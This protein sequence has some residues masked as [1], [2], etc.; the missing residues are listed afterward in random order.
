MFLRSN[1][2][3]TEV[4]HRYSSPQDEFPGSEKKGDF[5][6]SSTAGCS[7]K[8]WSWTSRGS[9]TKVQNGLAK[10]EQTHQ[11]GG[12]WGMENGKKEHIS[13]Q[14]CLYTLVVWT[15]NTSVIIIIIII[16]LFVQNLFLVVIGTESSTTVLWFLKKGWVL[17]LVWPAWTSDSNG[18]QLTDLGVTPCEFWAKNMFSLRENKNRR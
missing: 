4:E 16:V 8:S 3:N 18:L 2:L 12:F 6:Q 15:D 7:S 10:T 5:L 14:L 11:F 1:P 13:S 9:K 17:P